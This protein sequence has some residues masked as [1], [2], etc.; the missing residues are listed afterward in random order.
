MHPA[1][2]LALGGSYNGTGP[3]HESATW[4]KVRGGAGFFD[5]DELDHSDTGSGVL[6]L[7]LDPRQYVED[8]SAVVS[9]PQVADLWAVLPSVTPGTY[10]YCSDPRDGWSPSG[11]AE[12]ACDAPWPMLL[13]GNAAGHTA[14]PI[15]GPN[16]SPV[17]YPVGRVSAAAWSELGVPDDSADGVGS[18]LVVGTVS[19]GTW[20]GEF[21]W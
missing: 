7:A 2:R 11:S 19:Q 18:Y 21:Q 6:T 4:R 20:R 15:L 12:L 13:Q 10:G 1:G 9:H 16:G 5:L 8:I 14:S 3:G 17:S